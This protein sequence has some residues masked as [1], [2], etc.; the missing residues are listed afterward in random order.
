MHM[1]IIPG[2]VTAAS[3]FTAGGV[4]CSI[5]PHNT[6]RKDLALLVADTPC[7]AAGVYTK[8]KVQSATIP[9]TKSHLENGT[10]RAVIVNS[11]IANTCVKD[12]FDIANRMCALAGEALGI[13][14]EEV[15]VASTGVIGQS[16]PIA[17]IQKGIG[18]LKNQL[19]KEGG[20]DAAQAIL[21]TDTFAKEIACEWEIGGKTV[22]MGGIAKGSG[23]VHVNMG[24]MLAFLTTDAAISPHMLDRALREVVEDTFNMVSVDG[25]TSTNDM[26][27]VLASGQAGNETIS[28]ENE[29]YRH[30]LQALDFCCR[31]LAKKIAGDGEGATKLLICKVSGAASRQDARLAA[32]TVVSSSLLKAAIFGKD[33]N[34]GRILCALGYSPAAMNVNAIDV[35]ISSKA[36][37]VQVCEQGYGLDFDE[38]LAKAILTEPEVVVDVRLQ[39]GEAAAEAYGCDLTYDYIRI[40]GDYRS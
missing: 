40:N 8:N 31:D 34:W 2:N 17:P 28:E 23:M 24:T 25:D 16:L 3:G 37:E 19:T 32:K 6:K 1:K 29:D 30:F 35:W 39:D 5:R 33:A 14:K 13:P 11:Y 9:V 26:L 4:C 10:A 21:T 20:A 27:L 38:P 18:L 15:L 12:G 36:G 7:A 22:R